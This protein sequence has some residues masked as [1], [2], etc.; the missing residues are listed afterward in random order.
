EI[1]ATL[2]KISETEVEFIINQ[3]RLPLPVLTKNNT[4]T[5]LSVGP[6][7]QTFKEP[8]LLSV[9]PSAQ[10]FKEPSLLSVGPSAQIFKEPSLN[11]ITSIINRLR[12]SKNTPLE[13]TARTDKDLNYLVLRSNTFI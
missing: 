2:D 7:A 5:L 12:S 11:K 8:S 13:R 3:N 9:G 1:S 10:I 4:P 6:S